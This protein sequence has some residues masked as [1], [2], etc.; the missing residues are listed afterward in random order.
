M[1]FSSNDDIGAPF[2]FARYSASL[3]MLTNNGTFNVTGGGDFAAHV[4]GGHTI[5]NAGIWNVS[6]QGTVSQ[7]V[8]RDHF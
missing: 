3:G 6:A 5:N 1:T 8:R 4:V 2:Y 7:R